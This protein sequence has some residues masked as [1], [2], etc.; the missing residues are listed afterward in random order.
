M[1]NKFSKYLKKK[2]PLLKELLDKLLEQYEYVSILATDVFG[3]LYTVNRSSTSVGDGRSAECGFVIKVY[4]KGMYFEYATNKIDRKDIDKIIEE[5]GKL[6]NNKTTNKQI[7]IG[8]I[9]EEEITKSFVRK[10]VGKKYQTEE[11]ISLLQELVNENLRAEKVINVNV[12]VSVQEVSK[13]FL[14]KNKDLEQYYNYSNGGAMVLVG[15]GSNMKYAYDGVDTNSLAYVMKK[16]PKK[17]VEV[18][19]L[20]IELLNAELIKPGVYT[21]VTDPSITGLI[22]HEAFGHGVEMDQF[23][24]DRAIAQEYIN[25]PVASKLV[26]MH[27]GAAAFNSVASYFFDDDG[28]LAQDTLIIENGILKRGI[29]D[30]T[31]ALQLGTKPT[32]NGRRQAFNHKSYSRMTNT[33]F[34]AGESTLKELIKS[35]DYGYYISQTSNGMEDPK[36]WGIQ[37]SAHVGREI[38]NGKFTGKIVSPVVMSGYVI[39][40]L[41]SISGI[42]KDMVISGS[43]QCGKGYKE[44]VRVSDGGPC[45]KAEVKIG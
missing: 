29:S 31:S 39:D 6:V 19:K 18:R 8:V 22:A 38:K 21:I 7:Q 12:M 35:V 3:K 17:I 42:S 28:V 44:W 16:M 24:K 13:L 32:G 43:G 34:E 11:I 41:M 14:S 23:V 9:N 10:N 4:D 26:N 33:F 25:K 27:D 30:V 37:C 40:L 5:V 20:A 2:K 36:N 45:L 15:E 1:E